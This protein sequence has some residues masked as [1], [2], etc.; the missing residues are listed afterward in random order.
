M[1]NDTT[2]SPAPVTGT[3]P[4]PTVADTSAALPPLL[5]PDAILTL[6]RALK[7]NTHKA[8][9]SD[10][11]RFWAAGYSITTDDRGLCQ[12]LTDSAQG[13]NG[14]RLAPRSCARFISSFIRYYRMQPA[15]RDLPCPAASERVKST[16]AGLRLQFGRPAKQAPGL[17]ITVLTTLYAELTRQ[18]DSA[19]TPVARMTAARDRAL[20][21]VGFWRGVRADTLSLLRA[22]G[23]EFHPDGT[24]TV[25]FPKEKQHRSNEGRAVAFEPWPILNPVLATAAWLAYF[26]DR[27]ACLFPAIHPGLG[28]RKPE[29]GMDRQKITLL[30]RRRL[31]DIGV[32]DAD[33]YS[34]HSLRHSLGLWGGQFLDIK[35][36]MEQGGWA[37]INSVARYISRHQRVAS[38]AEAVRRTLDD[39]QTDEQ[40]DQ[41][42]DTAARLD[43]R[44]RAVP[45]GKQV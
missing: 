1:P 24:M 40:A 7:A 21:A 20:L 14:T 34:A 43:A 27:Q 31:H 39:Q 2:S 30:L 22:D 6:G 5:T 4:T 42:T 8:M 28:V 16:L 12:Y 32:A 45:A 13:L 23:V 15:L 9:V 26:P 41:Q 33:R 29:V 19:A 35:D 25:Y 37:S 3:A 44:Y 36:L 11:K 17:S 18:L 38:L 10:M